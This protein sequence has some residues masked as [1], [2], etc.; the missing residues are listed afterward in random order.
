MIAFFSANPWPFRQP[1][2]YLPYGPQ[3]YVPVTNVTEGGWV[4][5]H[6]HTFSNPLSNDKVDLIREKCTGDKVLMACR[7][8]QRRIPGLDDDRNPE[9]LTVLA[10]ADREIV[11]GLSNGI[12]AQGT[13]FKGTLQRWSF[14]SAAN[15]KD[16][17]GTTTLKMNIAGDY[18]TFCC[19]DDWCPVPP[20]QPFWE[21]LFY[22]S[23]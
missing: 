3:T 14:T 20:L 4:K 13:K 12:V 7:P 15:P 6:N 8:K 21:A 22:H 9:Q 18:T 2:P 17:W 19:G 16:D 10:W 5:C 11:F 23:S 1:Q